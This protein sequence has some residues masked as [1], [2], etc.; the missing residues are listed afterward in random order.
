M[1]D[2]GPL[3]KK[4]DRYQIDLDLFGLQAFYKFRR[5]KKPRIENYKSLSIGE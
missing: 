2:N 3:G 4:V 1:A 5:A